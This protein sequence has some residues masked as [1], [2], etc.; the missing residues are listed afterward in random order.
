MTAGLR[1]CRVCHRAMADAMSP[2]TKN[3]SVKLP[4]TNAMAPLI[5][6]PALLMPPRPLRA[7]QRCPQETQ[8]PRSGLGAVAAGLLHRLARP[9]MPRSGHDDAASK[10]AGLLECGQEDL[11]L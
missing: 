5:K 3:V 6:R 10:E 1:G 7:S 2:S 4:S 9:E 11:R 8:Q